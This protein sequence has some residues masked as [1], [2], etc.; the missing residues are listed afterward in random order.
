MTVLPT[1]ANITKQLH[2]SIFFAVT[3]R[4]LKR[5]VVYLEIAEKAYKK[6]SAACRQI[7]EYDRAYFIGKGWALGITK[8]RL[9]KDA[10]AHLAAYHRCMNTYKA[11]KQSL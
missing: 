8:E 6:W 1:Q 4:K 7:N 5:A 2:D 9:R 3:K 10:S 11:I